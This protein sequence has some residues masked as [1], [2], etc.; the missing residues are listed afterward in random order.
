MAR[1]LPVRLPADPLRLTLSEEP[2]ELLATVRVFFFRAVS[3]KP[4]FRPAARFERFGGRF[5]L[6]VL[7]FAKRSPPTTQLEN[8]MERIFGIHQTASATT[9]SFEE[10]LRQSAVW[11]ALRP[12]RI[13]PLV[14]PVSHPFWA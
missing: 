13:I 10:D 5:F 9:H 2:L 6:F 3:E 4:V 8:R 12:L 1:R 14:Q 7:T 11:Q